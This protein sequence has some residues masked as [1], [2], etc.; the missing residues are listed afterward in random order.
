MAPSSR[1]AS[2]SIA[3]VTSLV[4]LVLVRPCRVANVVRVVDAAVGGDVPQI[5]GLDDA[6]LSPQGVVW[7]TS[8]APL[9]GLG[10]P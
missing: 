9:V 1:A 6:T 2:T 5:D 7:H 8:I 10:A 4:L 3:C